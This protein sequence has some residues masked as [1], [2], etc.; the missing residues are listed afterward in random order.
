MTE[1]AKLL[2]ATR[3]EN[4]VQEIAEMLDDVPVELISL[5]GF[6]D[7]PPVDEDGATFEENAIKK[8]LHVWQHTGMASIADDSGLEVDALNGE[9]GV[10]S[11]RYA[12][13]PV[14]YE[15]NNEK[16]LRMLEDVP[17]EDRKATFVCVAVLVSSKGKVVLQ[18]GELKGVITGEPRGSGG[19]GYDPVFYLP[20]HKKT[21]AE[22][23][24]VTKNQISHRANAFAAI[25]PFICALT[26]ASGS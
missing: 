2:L 5:A 9:P 22:L 10:K 23:D 21:V 26:P 3:N 6:P 7:V 12:G 19:F 11:A 17:Q 4:K 20:R 16:L 18:R 24:A 1:R 13:E 14:S 8:A 25:K 15:A